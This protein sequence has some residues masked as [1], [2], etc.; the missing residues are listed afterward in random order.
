MEGP[1]RKLTLVAFA[2]LVLSLI[3]P[4]SAFADLEETHVQSLP[5]FSL[6]VPLNF[7]LNPTLNSPPPLPSS[8]VI[9]EHGS[10]LTLG[11]FAPDGSILDGD[12]AL[13][14][15]IQNPS[16][17]IKR[18]AVYADPSIRIDATNTSASGTILAGASGG[19]PTPSDFVIGGWEFE[20]D[21]V[22]AATVGDTGS[23][24]VALALLD[25]R[26]TPLASAPGVSFKI[27]TR[28]SNGAV[29]FGNIVMTPC[30]LRL[31]RL[32]PTSDLPLKTSASTG[33]RDFAAA[34]VAEITFSV[35]ASK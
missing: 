15:F 2:T 26:D 19:G 21:F 28:S 1:L 35:S 9:I 14:I 10:L 25:H 29:A 27:Q 32:I 31:R 13:V 3:P 34:R 20:I 30:W 33:F 24:D 12:A 22:K 11:S 7:D 16:S 5:F 18:V 8:N 23:F 6:Q 17:L 4:R